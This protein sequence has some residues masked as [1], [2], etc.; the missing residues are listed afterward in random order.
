MQGQKPCNHA[1]L[2]PEY[3][4]LEIGPAY[5]GRRRRGLRPLDT[6]HRKLSLGYRAAKHPF[7]LLDQ[8]T[9]WR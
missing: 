7:G 5:G 4:H 9:S 8:R 2:A 3:G 1:R 6:E